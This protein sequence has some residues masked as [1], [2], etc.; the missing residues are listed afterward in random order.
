MTDRIG[1]IMKKT[2]IAIC[3]GVGLALIG[4]QRVDNTPDPADDTRGETTAPV[5]KP[6][7]ASVKPASVKPDA[8]PEP[9]VKPEPAAP[10]PTHSPEEITAAKELAT[11]LGIAVEEDRVVTDRLYGVCP[12]NRIVVVMM[13]PVV[14]LL[15]EN[16]AVIGQEKRSLIHVLMVVKRP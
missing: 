16:T 2:G 11:N 12:I 9:D 7:P 15:E 3:L 4:C 6:E 1:R 14:T 8:E 13:I 5:S 10:K